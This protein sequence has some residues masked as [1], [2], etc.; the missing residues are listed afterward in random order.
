MRRALEIDPLSPSFLADRG[1]IHY[2]ARNYPEAENYCS[3]ALDISP[4]FHFAH[5]Y[6]ACIYLKTGRQDEALEEYVKADSML[7][8]RQLAIGIE[9]NCPSCGHENTEGTD[10]CDNC[11]AP[12][13]DL[14]V[15]R[16]D[17]AEG[18]ARSV[19]EDNLSQLNH[20]ESVTVAPETSARDV[21]ERMKSSNSGCALVLD[22]AQLIGIFTEHDVLRKM[23]GENAMPG[24]VPVRELMTPNPETLQE[25][26]SV[27]VA[28]NKMSLG[29]YRHIPV[30]RKDR[31]YTV[32][33]IKNVL[34]YIA[35]EDW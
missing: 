27:A 32:V 33:S 9:M 29:E 3:R 18:L 5:Q 11:L 25:K 8:N 24:S 35:K 28:L 23:T 34:D 16:A 19:M 22:G 12:F 14:D 31:S 26:D 17:S 15:P 6:L 30:V 21:I 20:E 1:Q 4:D 7:A 2:F 10:R 13:S